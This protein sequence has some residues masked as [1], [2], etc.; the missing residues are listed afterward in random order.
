[1][2]LFKDANQLKALRLEIELMSNLKNPN[3]VAMYDS[4]IG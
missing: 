1:M 2:S 4:C 3:I